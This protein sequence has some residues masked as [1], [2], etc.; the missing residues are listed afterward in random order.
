MATNWN[1]TILSQIKPI[2]M[3]FN[4]TGCGACNSFNDSVLYK[5]IW[6]K[7][8]CKIMTAVMYYMSK[9]W[10]M[11]TLNVCE[12]IMEWKNS[13]PKIIKINIKENNWIQ[14]LHSL[15]FE[16]TN[17]SP[18]SNFLCFWLSYSQITIFQHFEKKMATEK[19]NLK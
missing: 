19:I 4:W 17:I 13:I 10:I 15:L 1:Q 14:K 12:F 3:T 8:I 7:C 6:M 9:V 2:S 16:N 18:P 5:V 11:I